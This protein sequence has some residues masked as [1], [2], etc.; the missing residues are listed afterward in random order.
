MTSADSRS[1][2]PRVGEYDS[3]PA[4]PA[5]WRYD[6]ELLRMRCFVEVAEQLSFRRAAERLHYSTAHLSQQIKKLENEL[7][8]LLFERSSR[9]VALTPAGQRV[10]IRARDFLLAYERVIDAAREA[11]AGLRSRLRVYYSSGSGGAAK[12]AIRAFTAGNPHIEISL[13]QVRTHQLVRALREGHADVAFALASIEE[14]TGLSAV[15]LGCYIQ[16]QLAL[17][18]DHPL[19]GQESVTIYDLEG[20]RLLLPSDDMAN[21][22]SRRILRFLAERG[23]VPDHRIQMISN[24]E[25]FLD[26]VAAGLGAAL[27][28]DSIRQ[29]WENQPSIRFHEL[30]GEAPHIPQLMIWDENCPQLTELLFRSLAERCQHNTRRFTTLILRRLPALPDLFRKHLM[31]I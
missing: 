13:T 11:R 15:T 29:R 21:M 14:I 24:E 8:L 4:S 26:A 28:G 2:R 3:D 16:N 30:I 7:G 18:D 10:L 22:H 20:Q 19:A 12:S 27:V 25:A 6:V 17:P 31:E 9:G 5:H 23:I 1:K